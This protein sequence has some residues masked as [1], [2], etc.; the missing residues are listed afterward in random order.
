MAVKNRSPDH[1][2]AAPKNQTTS[3]YCSRLDMVF[4]A[5]KERLY[6]F[7]K[8]HISGYKNRDRYAKRAFFAHGRLDK[9]L[10]LAP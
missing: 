1:N 3:I 8:G 9:I 10:V 5:N 2:H 6:L 7:C 4:P